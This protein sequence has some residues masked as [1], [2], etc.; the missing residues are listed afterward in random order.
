MMKIVHFV[1][2]T[3]LAAIAVTADAQTLSPHW[4]ELTAEDFVKALDQAKGVC[5]LPFGIIE[6]HGPSGPMGTDLMNVRYA[7]FEA[8]KKEYAIVF[9]EYY[10]GQIFEAKHQPGTLAYST[11]LQLELLQETTAEMARN[12]CKKVAIVSGHGGNTNLIQFFVQTTLETPKDYVIY[13]IMNQNPAGMTPVPGTQASKPGVDGHAGEGEIANVMAH[14][15]E[16]VHTDRAAEESGRDLNRLDLPTNVYTGIWWYA[17]FPNHYQGD[18]AG[19]T[20]AR[21]RALM[22]QRSDSIA[23]AIRAIK[24]DQV[25]PRLQKEFFDESGKPVNTKQ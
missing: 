1:T 2:V 16:L 20:A 25:G 21:G 6:K 17:K 22:Q 4:E 3:F 19:A 11:H 5:I 8:V 13:A 12:G 10:F 7:A 23:S 14:R 9:P 24:S 15:P 18:A